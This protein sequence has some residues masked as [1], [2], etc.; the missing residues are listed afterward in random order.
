MA[1]LKRKSPA[2]SA[3]GVALGTVRRGRDGR[4]W[5]VVRSG[6]TKRWSRM[7]RVAVKRRRILL[8]A[9]LG[10]RPKRPTKAQLRRP[11][12]TASATG[13]PVGYQM[14]GKDGRQWRIIRSRVGV[15]RWA[16]VSLF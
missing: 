16:R 10:P 6:K 7:T 4:K 9:L 12:P 8:G 1:K 13:Y 14:R 11:S 15:K 5:K 2:A 3:T